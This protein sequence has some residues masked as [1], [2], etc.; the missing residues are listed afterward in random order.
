KARHLPYV[1]TPHID[2]LVAQGVNFT[3]GYGCHVCSPARSSLQSGFHQ[4]HTFADRNDPDNAKKAMRA[5]EVLIGDAL[6]AAGYATGYWG[7]W[8]YGGSRDRIRPVIEN[9]QTLPTSHGYRHVL[10]ELHHVRAHTFF[11]PT[12][13]SAPANPDAVGGLELIP[14]SMDRYRNSRAWPVAPALQNH[15]DYPET[16]YCDDSYAFAALDFVRI[17]GQNYNAGGQPFFGLLAVQIPHAPFGEVATLPEWDRAYAGDPHYASLASQTRQWAAM[18]SRIDAHFGNILNA[19]EDPDNDGDQSDSIA[20]NTLVI[21]QSDN[22]GPAG[23]NNIELDA[24]GGLS[25]HKGRIQEGGIRVPLV[26][27]WPAEI[28][29]DTALKA[30]SNCD[31]VVDVTDLLPTFC[32]L[33]GAPVPLGIDGVSIAPTLRNRGHQRRRDFII[34]EAGNGQSIIRG[35]HK[36]V[37][38]KK[39]PLKLYDLSTDHAEVSNIAA[40]HPELVRELE[41]LLLGERV[42][43]PKGFASTYHHWTGADGARTAEPGN[44]S[45]YRYT[46]AGITY[47][48]DSGAPQLSWIAHLRNTGNRSNIAHVDADMEV[49]GLEV[50]GNRHA[51]AEQFLVV[52]PEVRLTGRN[53]IRV[54]S[55]GTLSLIDGTLSSLRWIDIQ[56]GGTLQG[57]GAIRAAVYN[58]GAIHALFFNSDKITDSRS[59]Q[60][61]LSIVGDY[62]QAA[63]A[64]L[65]ARISESGTPQLR[66]SGAA[67][68]G[69]RLTIYTPD[70]FKPVSGDSYSV[71]AAELIE[72]R[73]N[74]L[75][76]ELTGSNGFRFTI[77]YSKTAVT[78]TVK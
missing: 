27:R 14:N 36:L 58:N 1:R 10:A 42:A 33:A 17:Q 70:D 68:L 53:E 23:K 5:D 78:V 75:N 45:D 34:H 25:G 20:G 7:K 24:N 41:T 13:W 52:G 18:V 46:N 35:P 47:L 32:E 43:E 12:L 29:T 48:Q 3:R 22:G 57:C 30:G 9:V 51:N 64:S 28:T 61:S 37:R 11:Q 6:S 31:L 21:F 54:G 2:R 50:L 60:T 72:G 74:N 65:S 76:N 59:K 63:T 38:S 19:L 69:G 4:G 77:G 56:A 39:Q 55:A 73:F 67:Q 44:W 16:A 40:T 8:G 71:L 26:M 49:L 15:A 62:H 66:I